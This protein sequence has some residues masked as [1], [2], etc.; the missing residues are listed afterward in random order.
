MMESNYF[1]LDDKIQNGI[2][3]IL[4][5]NSLTPIQEETIPCLLNGDNCILIAQLL[6]EKPKQ[7]FY[8]LYLKSIREN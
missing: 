4:K 7:H 1:L 2:K 6:E 3:D 5:W 8:L